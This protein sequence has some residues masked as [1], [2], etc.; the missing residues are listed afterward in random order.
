MISLM[1]MASLT[2]PDR[3][4]VFPDR[5]EV[6]RIAAVSCGGRSTTVFSGI[7]PGAKPDSFRARLEGGDVEGLRSELV[8]L[9][10][11]Y[12]PKVQAEEAATRQLEEQRAALEDRRTR[13][14]TQLEASNHYSKLAGQLIAR[15]MTAGSPD[16]KS[17]KQAFDTAQALSRSAAS[18]L[19]EVDLAIKRVEE[20]SQAAKAQLAQ[21]RVG[22]SRRA[23]SVEVLATC[24]SGQRGELELT[25]VVSGARW[26]PTY[27][28]RANE[29]ERMVE[30]STWATVTQTT[31]EPWDNV[32]LVLSTAL[33]AEDAT[34]PTLLPV[35]IFA[36]ERLEETRVLASREETVA[37]AEQPRHPGDSNA[38][39]RLPVR[40][41]ATVPGDGTPG[42][43]GVGQVRL[44]A[45][46]SLQVRPSLAPFAFRVAEV[47][48]E[49]AW[50]LLPGRVDCYRTTG[51]VGQY[52]LERVPQGAPFT[53]TFGTEDAVRVK[54]TPIH[55]LEKELVGLGT[56]LRLSSAY[57]F[58]V[59]NYGQNPTE[60][61]VADRLPVSELD[62][63]SVTV[64]P[65]TTPGS[66]A[67]QADGIITWALKLAP[68]ENKAVDF[69]YQLEMPGSYDVNQ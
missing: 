68:G 45:S 21:L 6:T 7:P 1:I 41:R 43:V 23:F 14:Q 51:L 58:Q 32:S 44:A 19:A 36:T 38:S 25:Y 31:G 18:E 53:L 24:P 42:S 4:V 57:R 60:V 17:W 62:D 56:R 9:P 12:A 29:G 54:R 26:R 63:I 10:N 66:V 20:R 65:K 8:F 59:S 48:N 69:A 39:I 2:A 49:G 30:L 5:A 67:H 15:E 34:P 3:V 50:P 61:I 28:A 47:S 11:A 27:E 37:H 22:A 33:P 40:E 35:K 16:L 13:A 46:F 64:S 55:E 52:R